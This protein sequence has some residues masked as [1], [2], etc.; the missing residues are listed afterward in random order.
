MPEPM[1]RVQPLFE[2]VHGGLP[3]RVA[4]WRCRGMA[5]LC[6]ETKKRPKDGSA[7]AAQKPKEELAALGTFPPE[8]RDITC[9]PL[10]FDLAFPAIVAPDIEEMLGSR[11]KTDEKGLAGRVAGG[12]GR[13][14]GGLGGLGG[15]LGG[16][17]GRK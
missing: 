10:L 15:R 5:E 3:A 6:A 16:F 13:V 2:E 8:F 4:Q 1:R 17:L 9:K 12:L 11:K 14:A 7:P